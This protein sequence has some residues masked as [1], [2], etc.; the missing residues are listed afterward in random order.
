MIFL[1][2][3]AEPAAGWG[4]HPDPGLSP[5]GQRQAEAASQRLGEMGAKR[6]VSSP[7]ARCR[8]T[9]RA[10][11]KQLETHARIEP[12]VGE[13]RTPAGT[14]DRT[15]WLKGIMAGTW[16]DAGASLQ[17]WREDVLKAVDRC[18]PETAVFTH[19]VAINA[20]VSL[21]TKDDRVLVFRPSHCS[22][23]RLD[24]RAG[25]LVVAELGGEGETVVT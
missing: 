25:Q 6:A 8:E 14:A 13:V 5:L 4:D 24:R 19:F 21:L 9:A 23:T 3:H 1:I 10:F 16:T 22:I 12:G 11:E 2:R 7:L 18:P 17:T 20:I 15:A